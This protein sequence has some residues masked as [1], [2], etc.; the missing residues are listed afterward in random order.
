MNGFVIAVPSYGRPIHCQKTLRLLARHQ[1]LGMTTLF[2]VQGEY[3]DYKE[4]CLKANLNPGNIVIG[5]AGLVAQRR[6]I[7]S[8][9]P[10]NTNIFMM[11]DDIDDYIDISGASVD[12]APHIK[13]GFDECVIHGARLFGLYAVPNPFFMKDTVSVD[14][15]FCV[16]S[17]YGI[18][19]RGPEPA[20]PNDE[21]TALKEDYFRT[22]AYWMADKKIVRINFISPKTKYYKGGGGLAS[23]RSPENINSCAEILK[24]MYPD[25]VTLF[26]RKTTGFTEVRLKVKKDKKN[27]LIAPVINDTPSATSAD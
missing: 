9:Y 27:I 19:K 5:H 11:D 17:S 3:N 1:L 15:K 20:V 18:I 24:M 14:L 22:C 6:F 21:I 23:L 2:V 8:H 4:E 25:I 10:E 7:Y 16:G 12:I 26:T 13:F